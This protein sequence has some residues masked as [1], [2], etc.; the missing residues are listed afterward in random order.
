VIEVDI[1]KNKNN[2]ENKSA[3]DRILWAH[4]NFEDGLFMSTSFGIQSAVLLHLVKQK[5]PN[6]PIIFIDTGYLF[7][8]T[9]QF[10][11][12]LTDDL[13]LNIKI[14]KPLMS[15]S[16]QENL[17]G[18]L[19]EQGKEG[20]DRYNRINKVEPMQRAIKEMNKTGWI[21]GLRREQSTSREHRPVLEHQNN[22]TK[23][24]PIIDWSDKQIDNYLSE[25]NLPNHPLRKKGYVSVGDW[26][27]STPLESNMKPEET[28]FNG[29]KRECGLHLDFDQGGGI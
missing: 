11:K 16:K 5:I 13:K 19:W 28:R 29:I 15:S 2:L 1:K 12:K 22:I 27:S 26:H 25:N 17:Y 6:I 24:Y 18:K 20:L 9:Y 21:A 7:S 23:I 4:K 8:E 10:A 14:Y 3:L